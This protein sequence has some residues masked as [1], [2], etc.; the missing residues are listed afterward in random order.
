[1]KFISGRRA[2]PYSV[3]IYGPQGA[4]K[5][6]LAADFPAPVFISGQEGSYEHDVKR[7]AFDPRTERTYPYTWE[8]VLGAVQAMKSEADYKTLVIDELQAIELLCAAYVCKADNVK[9]IGK[10]GGGFGNGEKALLAEMRNLLKALEDVWATG[11]HVV[12]CAHARQGKVPHPDT[13]D[14]IQRYEPTL[15]SANT[16]D[17]MG[18]FFGWVSACLFVSADVDLIEKGTG[19]AKKYIGSETGRRLART[20]GEAR[21]AA[22]CR[23]AGVDAVLDIPHLHPM[24]QFFQQATEGRDLTFMQGKVKRLADEA[25]G[26]WPTKVGK[27][28]ATPEA[29]E[30]RSL[31]ERVAFLR[32]QKP[33]ASPAA[34]A[35]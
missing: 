10:I 15:T 29:S 5:T 6:T 12:L 9:N 16:G 24:A 30:L 35:A 34:A 4:G 26:D 13:G 21:W 25:G 33:E 20:S 7:Y 28:L 18:M 31:H 19:I 8:E 32:A 1:M 17:V 3:F 22:K 27:W 23:Y 11:K 14:Q 2:A